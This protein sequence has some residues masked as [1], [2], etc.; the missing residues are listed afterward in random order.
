MIFCL[1]CYHYFEPSDDCYHPGNVEKVA[2]HKEWVIRA[3]KSPMHINQKNDCVWFRGLN[4]RD[5]SDSL[6]V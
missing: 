6:E 3:K 2:T 4:D 1:G 5:N